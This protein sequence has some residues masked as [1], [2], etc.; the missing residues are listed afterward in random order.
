[1]RSKSY[2]CEYCKKE[3]VSALCGRC[4]RVAYC[5][6]NCQ[7]THWA[8]HKVFCQSAEKSPWYEN[9]K[10][11]DKKADDPR[12]L[13]VRRAKNFVSN[14]EQHVKNPPVL[15]Y[16]II[17]KRVNE[18]P[19]S[20]SYKDSRHMK[21]EYHVVIEYSDEKSRYIIDPLK[22]KKLFEYKSWVA[23]IT[24]G[25]PNK[26]KCLMVRHFDGVAIDTGT[27]KVVGIMVNNKILNIDQ[28]L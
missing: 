12:M 5:D 14:V 15:N 6:Q 19:D 17:S 26:F 13:C 1:M 11:W 4:K 16:F 3:N 24:Q 25:V 27:R 22:S 8:T 2:N 9:D 28:D 23:E 7:K 20:L 10:L 21:W 18:S